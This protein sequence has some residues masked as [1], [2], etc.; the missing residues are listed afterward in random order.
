MRLAMSVSKK[1]TAQ[2]QHIQL[3]YLMHVIGAPMLAGISRST[4]ENQAGQPHKSP[5][6]IISSVIIQLPDGLAVSV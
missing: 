3:L 5:T 4:E 1:D 2:G 6:N